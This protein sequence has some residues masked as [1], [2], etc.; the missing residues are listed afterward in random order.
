MLRGNPSKLAPGRLRDAVAPTVEIPRAPTH[1]KGAAL[2]EW[3]RVTPELETLGLIS[4]ID[5]AALAMYCT[6]WGRYVE[7][8]EKIRELGEKGLVDITPNGFKVQGV[9]LN[10]ANKAMEQCKSFLAE[11][12]MSPSARSRVTPS[13]ATGDLF[14]G[15]EHGKPS[16]GSFIK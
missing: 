3:K 8:E 7:A 9:W 4:R 13:D 12:G 11:F 10:V 16:I 15:T 5:V 14:E 1:L 2:K 6:A